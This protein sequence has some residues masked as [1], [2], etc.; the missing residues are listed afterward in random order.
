MTKI[1]LRLASATVLLLGLGVGC[2]DCGSP[3]A[4]NGIPYAACAN[5]LNTNCTTANIKKLDS[6]Y[7]NGDLNIGNGCE[8]FWCRGYYK[9]GKVCLSGDTIKCG[10]G[11]G[12]TQGTSTCSNGNWGPC[13]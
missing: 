9:T 11:T 1:T 6:L 3:G 12:D 13:Q 4:G 8:Q 5:G 10:L 7:P 2:D